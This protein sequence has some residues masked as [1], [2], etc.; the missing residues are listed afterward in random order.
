MQ[1]ELIKKS[2]NLSHYI[3]ASMESSSTSVELLQSTA[4]LLNVDA[5][6]LKDALKKSPFFVYM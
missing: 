5:V 2:R 6:E 1:M 4:L 3:I